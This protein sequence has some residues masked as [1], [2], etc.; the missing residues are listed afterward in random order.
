MMEETKVNLER[1]TLPEF[2]QYLHSHIYENI[3]FVETKNSFVLGIAGGFITVLTVS[4][5]SL[6]SVIAS[7][8]FSKILFYTSVLG[9]SLSW[10]LTILYSLLSLS[11]FLNSNS[12]SIFYFD[13]LAKTEIGNLSQLND[14]QILEELIKHSKIL[15]KIAQI[16][17]QRT[18]RS[19]FFLKFSL[20]F[21]PILILSLT[22]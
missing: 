13:T 11:P 12:P 19:L 1:E 17:Y 10:L 7:T 22:I 21:I 8:I 4:I 15:A 5:P 18:S 2:V 9:L 20:F 3:K 6:S 16:K 14:R